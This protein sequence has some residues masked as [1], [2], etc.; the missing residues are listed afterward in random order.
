[1]KILVDGVEKDWKF[2]EDQ[3]LGETIVEINERILIDDRRVVIG[4]KVDDDDMP[5]EIKKLTP[6]QVTLDQVKQISFETQPFQESLAQEFNAA[7]KLIQDIQDSIS[8]IVGHIL[9][10]ELDIAMN[11]LRESV[12]KL[13]WVFNLLM[14]ASAINAIRLDDI[15]CGEGTLSEFMGR[16]NKTLQEMMDAMENN[17]TTLINDFLEYEM[18]PALGELKTVISPIREQII[19]FEFPD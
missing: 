5:E 3:T 10:D 1:M 2:D 18:E 4:I 13:I 14:Q 12:D 8:V 6:E 11:S 15:K 9:S 7:E 19:D 16:F 17:D